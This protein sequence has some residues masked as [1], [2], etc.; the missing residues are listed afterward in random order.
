MRISISFVSL[1]ATILG[2]IL[3]CLIVDH[4]LFP[5]YRGWAL[6]FLLMGLIILCR[7]ND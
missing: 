2:V 7:L 5:G 1:G 3:L 6:A 4:H